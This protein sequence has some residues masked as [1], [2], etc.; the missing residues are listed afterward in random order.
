MIEMQRLK[1]AEIIPQEELQAW[2]ASLPKSVA[3][4]CPQEVREFIDAVS[5]KLPDFEQFQKYS[6]SISGAEL[7][8]CGMREYKGE[9]IKPWIAYE[10]PV[11]RMQAVDHHTAMHRL[12]NRKGKQ[13]LIDYVKAHVEGSKIEP[14]LDMLNVHVFHQERKEFREVMDQIRQ[15]NKI[16]STIEV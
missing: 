14:L 5:R 8:L 12:F 2:R 1:L 9:Q 15:S 6:T 4:H 16:E 3:K 13:G 7:M 10:L 11:P